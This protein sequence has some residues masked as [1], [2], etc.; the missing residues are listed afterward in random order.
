MT[1]ECERD[2]I[3]GDLIA[4]D[5]TLPANAAAVHANWLTASNKVAAS[6]DV[7]VKGGAFTA[8]LEWAGK[9]PLTQWYVKVYAQGGGVDRFGSVAVQ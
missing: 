4:V 8:E 2:F 9:L 7:Q 1:L 5:P 3:L 6:A